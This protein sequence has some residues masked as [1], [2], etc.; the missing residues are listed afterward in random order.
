M[1]RLTPFSADPV[2]YLGQSEMQGPS[3]LSNQWVHFHPRKC[4]IS[5][6]KYLS[7]CRLTNWKKR[8]DGTAYSRQNW[9]ANR[10]RHTAVFPII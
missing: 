10:E 1:Y 3:G 5:G 8:L 6:H 4:D 2:P 9:A 7:E